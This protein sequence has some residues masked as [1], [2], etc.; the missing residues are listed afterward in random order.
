MIS[1]DILK[2]APVIASTC[3]GCGS[4]LLQLQAFPIVILDEATQSTEPETLCALVHCA[5][6]VV[7]LGDHH[8]L[9]PTVLSTRA[10][11]GG[12]SKSLFSRLV[13]LGIKPQVLNVQYRMHPLISEFPNQKF[14]DGGIKDGIQAEDREMI[15]GFNWPVDNSPV[16]FVPLSNSQESKTRMSF[17]NQSEARVVCDVLKQILL[18]NSSITAEDVGVISPYRGQVGLIRSML[19]SCFQDTPVD[20]QHIS[21]NTIDGFQDHMILHIQCERGEGKGRSPE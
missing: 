7:L 3:I 13:E 18:S 8:Q 21:T 4:S 15:F 11:A 10:Q 20:G 12:L 6:Q 9:P 16:A 19:K 14:Y 17:M 5:Q 1:K 2:T